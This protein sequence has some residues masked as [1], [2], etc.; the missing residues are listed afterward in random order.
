MKTLK[1]G[2]KVFELKNPKVKPSMYSTEHQFQLYGWGYTPN[3]VYGRP[4]QVKQ[5]IYDEWEKW[6]YENDV[7]YF[8]I[9]GH[10][11]MMFTLGGI[12]NVNG[13]WYYVNITK[14]HNTLTPM[15]A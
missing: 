14:A 8:G 4:S 12:V 3:D 7:K 9:T 11:C 10:N 5:Q 13:Q 15:I 6:A 2:N 1:I